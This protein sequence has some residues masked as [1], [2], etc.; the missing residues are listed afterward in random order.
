MRANLDYLYLQ[1]AHYILTQDEEYIERLQRKIE[2]EE[3]NTY[4]YKD[5]EEATK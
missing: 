4:K 2:H 5:K 1:Q 3:R